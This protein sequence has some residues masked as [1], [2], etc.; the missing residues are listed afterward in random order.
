MSASLDKFNRRDF[1]RAAGAGLAG[2]T[3]LGRARASSFVPAVKQMLVYVGTYTSHGAEGIYVLNLALD[4]GAL[5]KIGVIKDVIEPSFLTTD[6]SNSLLYTVNETNEYDGKPSGAVTAFLIEE[7]AGLRVINKVPSLGGS[8]CHITVSANDKFVLVANYM[9][10]NVSVF[11]VR[12]DGGLG[13][14]VELKQHQGSGPN[15]D[16]QEAAHAHAI[17]LDP[18]NKFALAADLG[19][20]KVMLYKFD[21]VTGKLSANAVPFFSSKAGAGP[22]HLAFHPNGKYVYIVNELDCTITATAYDAKL[23]SLTELQTVPTLPSGFS[24]ANTCAEIVVSPSGNC[25]YVSNRGHDTIVSY[26]ID[27]ATGKL[28]Y[29]EHVSTG[30]KTPRNFTIDPTGKFLLAANQNSGD[31]AVFNIDA[32]TGR[33]RSTGKKIDIPAPVCVRIVP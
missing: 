18:K 24:G 30:G 4:S 5:T 6:S 15:K 28:T 26:G 27:K 33:L 23:G 8:P 22:R 11:P 10:G 19:I 12:P 29:I 32:N 17:V 2:T 9:G 13:P 14:S 3:L 16:R 1:L 20:D 21:S 7:D 31:I 25:V